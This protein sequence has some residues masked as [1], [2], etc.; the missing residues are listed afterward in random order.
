MLKKWIASTFTNLDTLPS[1]QAQGQTTGIISNYRVFPCPGT[2]W[3]QY[4]HSGNNAER[5]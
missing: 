1:D 5:E 4:L 2:Y 3:L